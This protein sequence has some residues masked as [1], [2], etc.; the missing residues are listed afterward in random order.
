MRYKIR[1]SYDGSAFFGWQIQTNDRTVQGDLEKAL[2]M[3]TGEYIQVTGA[4]RTDTEVN[5]INYIVYW[6]NNCTANNRSSK[7]A[8]AN[9]VNPCHS[10]A[11]ILI[12]F[13]FVNKF[14]HINQE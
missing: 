14:I 5:A 9:F 12:I 8:T 4:G 13:S 1:L 11:T 6:H 2:K 7:W 3:L 10:I